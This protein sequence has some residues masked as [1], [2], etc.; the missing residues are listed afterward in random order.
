ML[1]PVIASAAL[2]RL[3]AALAAGGL[4]LRL[5]AAAP[6]SAAP[7]ALAATAA[8]ATPARR[9][10]RVRDRGGPRLAHALLAQ[11]LVL[12]VVL[13]A[14]AVVLRHC[15]T[16]V[17]IIGRMRSDGFSPL[18]GGRDCFDQIAYLLLVDVGGEIRLAD[19]ADEV[20]PVDHRQ[21]TDLVVGHRAQRLVDTVVGPDR[22][23][24]PLAEFARPRVGWVLA[25]GEHLY[26][27]VAVGEHSLEPVVLAAD[28][29]RAD[30]Q[31]GE[32]LGGIENGVVLADALGVLGH[33]VAGL[34]A[35]HRLSSPFGS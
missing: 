25:G 3:F 35:G 4:L 1:R 2:A 28:R 27:D 5:V 20:V 15:L 14:R 30:V 29:H 12:L 26:D 21:P 31:L 9:A 11:T 10:R 17:Q 22:D 16:S 18:P 8:L 24:L 19:D 7:L 6:A 33:D 34:L 23:W 32:P 13:D